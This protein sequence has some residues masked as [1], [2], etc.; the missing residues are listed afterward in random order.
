MPNKKDWDKHR[1]EIERLYIDEGRLD[2][3][4]TNVIVAN[5]RVSQDMVK[6]QMRRYI[7]TAKAID[8]KYGA[9]PAPLRMPDG[10]WFRTPSP[11]LPNKHVYTTW[12]V[13]SPWLMFL[14]SLPAAGFGAKATI[15]FDSSTP[16]EVAFIRLPTAA[17]EPIRALDLVLGKDC[18]SSA[19]ETERISSTA[20]RLR[21]LI[22]E[23]YDGQHLK[24]AEALCDRS[25]T[26]PCEEIIV[27]LFL[28]ANNFVFQSNVKS[29]YFQSMSAHDQRIV[30]LL[31]QLERNGLQHIK[32][33]FLTQ[34]PTAEAIR[35]QVFASVLRS[36][37]LDLLQFILTTGVNVNKLIDKDIG[38]SPTAP[39]PF[40]AGIGDGRK[41]LDIVN[42]LIDAGADV[43]FRAEWGDSALVCALRKGHMDVVNKLL[44]SEAHACTESLK[45]AI[46]TGRDEVMEM[47]LNAGIDV[48]SKL[49]L[50]DGKVT[51]IG[52]VAQQGYVKMARTL[53]GR[54]AD[55]NAMQSFE[56]IVLSGC[57]ND[58]C[59]QQYTPTT[60]LG[61]ALSKGHLDVARLL[62]EQLDVEINQLSADQYVC[63]LLIACDQGYADIA[64]ELLDAGAD[65]HAADASG[66]SL[67]CKRTTLLSA[68]IRQQHG[69]INM[70]LC[71]ALISKGARLDHPLL[72]AARSNNHELVTFL[73]SRGAC[74]SV[75]DPGFDQT[76]LGCAIE[77]GLVD[78]AE[79]LYGAGVID[80]GSPSCINHVDMAEFLHRTGLLP[81]ILRANGQMIFSD[82][83]RRHHRP[84][85]KQ[86][87]AHDHDIDFTQKPRCSRA[88]SEPLV[89]LDIA[90]RFG[91]PELIRYL[92]ERGAAFGRLTLRLAVQHERAEKILNTLLSSL[93]PTWGPDDIEPE[94]GP[95]SKYH[96]DEEDPPALINAAQLGDSSILQTLLNAV[97]WGSQRIG[98]AL[99]AAILSGNSDLVQD[100]R[101]AGASLDEAWCRDDFGGYVVSALAAAVDQENVDLATHLIKA[102]ANVHELTNHFAAR[103]ALQLAAEIGHL[104]LV[105]ILLDAGADVNTSPNSN[106]GATALQCAAIG[107]HLEV[108][109]RL[110]RAGANINAKGAE[111]DG[112]TALEG[113]AEHGRLEMV[114]LL[115]E[116]GARLMGI[117]TSQYVQ[118]V[119]LA[120]EN[121]HNAV[122]RFLESV[123]L[124]R[125]ERQDGNDNDDQLPGS[126]GAVSDGVSALDSGELGCKQ[127]DEERD[128]RGATSTPAVA[129]EEFRMLSES[130]ALQGGMETDWVTAASGESLLPWG[131]DETDA[132]LGVEP[133]G[134]SRVLEDIVMGESIRGLECT[135]GSQ[136]QIHDGVSEFAVAGVSPTMGFDGEGWQSQLEGGTGL[137]ID[138]AE[139]GMMD[140]DFDG[141]DWDAGPS[142][143]TEPFT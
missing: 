8:L 23:E 139:F 16:G 9:G 116:R 103:T 121:G 30:A 19:Q 96:L 46:I 32:G 47:I 89:P 71:E 115:L 69:K 66:M 109:R 73:L 106:G 11:E 70:D 41:S 39:L 120:K 31:H 93:P 21:K 102:G 76:A 100:L 78:M 77:E 59:L 129:P 117:Y 33:L 34:N 67:K 28:L 80:A 25:R 4:E 61:I 55:I 107:G 123:R 114:H 119:A 57:T 68:M 24:T 2:G 35:D 60:A 38:G 85:L 124:S 101:H 140:I 99:T 62:L 36:E 97:D 136:V 127:T 87:M 5:K 48:N 113:A 12:G 138:M 126:H 128:V 64:T 83:V 17:S 72:E 130:Q 42:L 22:P 142:R 86:L 3:K 75:S 63:P 49:K 98:E 105:D 95:V 104:K 143:H 58:D 118:A 92:L 10:V 81:G 125:T 51:P 13:E 54:G 20:L 82:A 52:L 79:L 14:G 131:N 6:K 26:W 141:F 94:D 74:S 43:N 40:A 122:A 132:M 27:Q 133:D 108:A 50:T 7:T 135:N 137:C 44:E 65:V 88:S 18:A 134:G 45:F 112:R 91:N 15:R 111:E 90:I 53:I 110:L 56:C 29:M 37:N 84:L 1:K